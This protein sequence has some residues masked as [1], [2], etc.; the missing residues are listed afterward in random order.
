[1]PIVA[2]K[3]KFMV[4][5]K[6][7]REVAVKDSESYVP[8]PSYIMNVAVEADDFDSAMTLAEKKAMEAFKPNAKYRAPQFFVNPINML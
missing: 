3:K 2:S 8:C 4:Y 7:L 1:M 6:I 5:Y